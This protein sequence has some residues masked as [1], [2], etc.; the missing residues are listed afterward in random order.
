MYGLIFFFF[1]KSTFYILLLFPPLR[2]FVTTVQHVFSELHFYFLGNNIWMSSSFFVV[3][4][5]KHVTFK[6]KMTPKKFTW[7]KTTVKKWDSIKKM[8][9]LIVW[10]SVKYIKCDYTDKTTTTKSLLHRYT[11]LLSEILQPLLHVEFH[12]LPQQIESLSPIPFQ[13]RPSVLILQT[14]FLLS[15][16]VWR[17]RNERIEKGDKGRAPF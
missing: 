17:K 10:Q 8:I 16:L 1:F 4:T 12:S 5:L 2:H 3:K 14:F 7:A 15:K 11:D 9:C 6:N 13:P